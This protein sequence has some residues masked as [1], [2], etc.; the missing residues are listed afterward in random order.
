MLTADHVVRGA[1]LDR[2]GVTFAGVNYGATDVFAADNLGGRDLA[3]IR[4]ARPV[5]GVIGA[6][7]PDLEGF[8]SGPAFCNLGRCC[9]L[10]GRLVS[11]G[12]STR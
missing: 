6:E 2:I 7:L 12:V 1:A 3:V 10:A 8:P 9:I 4:L 5:T 11:Y